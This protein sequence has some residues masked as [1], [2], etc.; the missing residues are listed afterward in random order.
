MNLF[1]Q[2]LEGQKPMLQQSIAIFKL[3]LLSD[4]RIP[5]Y[6][7]VIVSEPQDIVAHLL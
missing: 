4:K 7:G 1:H 5:Q 3:T 6:L 2:K